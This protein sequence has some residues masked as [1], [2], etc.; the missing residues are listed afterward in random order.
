MTTETEDTPPERSAMV[1]RS[2]RLL[3]VLGRYGQAGAR[4]V[5]LT[6]E[7]GLTR[8]A[9]LRILR[10][11]VDEGVVRL[12]DRHYRLGPALF[13]L[14]LAAQSPFGEM[15]PVRRIMRD[16]AYSVGDTVY[17]CLRQGD[18]VFYIAREEGDFPVRTQTVRV[19]DTKTMAE[20]YG[21]ITLLAALDP[22]EARHILDRL[23]PASV[24]SAAVR[25]R[26]IE[27]MLRTARQND[28]RVSG[29]DL[30]LRGL[31]GA[32][33]PIHSPITGQPMLAVTVSAIS[34]R[35]EDDRLEQIWPM[36]TR[37]KTAIEAILRGQDL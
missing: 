11:L 36:L 24:E 31:A 17:L 3:F 12:Q 4:L 19:G 34:P 15:V 18:D 33:L 6:R 27:T 2:C 5:D 9:A 10:T 8:P 35:L 14:G 13:Q 21:G 23:L 1:E 7:A 29:T 28:G 22:A 32:G 37:A 20:T 30:V 16:L 25:R 26:A